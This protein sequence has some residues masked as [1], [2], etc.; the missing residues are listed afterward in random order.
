MSLR[1][2]RNA[3]PME[4]DFGSRVRDALLLIGSALAVG[5]M[6][7]LV[8]SYPDLKRYLKMRAM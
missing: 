6:L 2:T 7:G 8:A 3:P 4:Q 1:N 5:L